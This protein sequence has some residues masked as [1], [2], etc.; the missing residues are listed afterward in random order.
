MTYMHNTSKP[1]R[2]GCFHA[3][4]AS[5]RKRLTVKY[6]LNEDSSLLRNVANFLYILSVLKLFITKIIQ[7]FKII[8]KVNYNYCRK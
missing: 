3:I 6:R 5:A 2:V 8:V 1:K 7:I 4:F